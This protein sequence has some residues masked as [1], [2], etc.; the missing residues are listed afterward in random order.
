M[1]IL[2]VAGWLGLPG[3]PL[4]WTIVPLALL[5][6]PSI[7]QFMFGLGRAFVTSSK[8]GVGEA[9]SGFAKASLVALFTLIFLPHQTLLSFDAILRALV[10][11]FITGERL[12]EWETAAQAEIEFRHRT[13]MDRY[14]FLTPLVALAIGALVYLA[15][16]Y[17]LHALAV[18]APILLVW[19]L[20]PL[21][22]LG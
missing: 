7:V 18:A 15:N 1:F 21:V 4:Y 2:F 20:A 3:G 8:G 17:P 13:P 16:P 11:R 5:I 19:S 9:L 10:R 14:L 12:L 22:A 6:F